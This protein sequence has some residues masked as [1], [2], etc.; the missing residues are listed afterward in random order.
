VLCNLADLTPKMLGA[1]QDRVRLLHEQM[2][3]S[4]RPPGW[5]VFLW[6]EQGQT[7]RAWRTALRRRLG[8]R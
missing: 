1:V 2:L 8:G 3:A 5:R 4:V 7:G 6:S